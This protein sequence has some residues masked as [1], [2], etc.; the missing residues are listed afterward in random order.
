M[1]DGE[2]LVKLDDETARRLDA[3]ARAAGQ[4]VGVYVADLIADRL[5]EDRF[6][7]AHAALEEYDRT[8]VGYD[9]ELEMAEFV[10]RVSARLSKD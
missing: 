7:E 5:G 8:G 4:P 9:A 2:I 1:A 6:A 3:V 10:S